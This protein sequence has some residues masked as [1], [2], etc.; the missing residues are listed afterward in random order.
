MRIGFYK[1]L[2]SHKLGSL[3]FHKERVR[4]SLSINFCT[5]FNN[6][7]LTELVSGWSLD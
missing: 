1:R 3:D 2:I 6:S 4:T 5:V 7:R